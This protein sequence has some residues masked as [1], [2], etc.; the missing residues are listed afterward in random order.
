MSEF[1]NQSSVDYWPNGRKKFEFKNL[2]GEI[3]VT[4]K[5]WKSNGQKK[6]EHFFVNRNGKSYSIQILWR[7]GGSI[8]G[9]SK[10]HLD[11]LS[12]RFNFI[13]EC[14][15]NYKIIEINIL[16]NEFFLI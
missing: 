3:Y 1:Q 8:Y 15:K 5:W 7:D 9:V 10:R 16:N 11:S 6:G 14:V 12:I 4:Q 2:E 13:N